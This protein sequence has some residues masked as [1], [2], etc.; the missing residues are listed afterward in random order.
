MTPS[1]LLK[2]LYVPGSL[3]NNEGG[4]ELALRNHIDSGTLVGLGPL[5]IDEQTYP[6][7][8]LVL[9]TPRGEWTGDQVSSRKPVFFPVGMQATIL[10]KAE[11]L[12]AGSHHLT[13][14][15]MVQEIGRI[16]FEVD[17]T[18]A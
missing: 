6:P 2:K 9:R 7:D 12:A 10:V 1:F 11:P 13:F 8:Q 18:I 17:D 3:K 14:A 15:A 16:Q 4:F 5:A